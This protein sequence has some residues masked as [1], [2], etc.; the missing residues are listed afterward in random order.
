[1]SSLIH[2]IKYLFVQP[3]YVK[4][5]AIDRNHSLYIIRS[6]SLCKNEVKKLVRKVEILYIEL[7]IQHYGQQIL[8]DISTSIDLRSYCFRLLG[9]NFFPLCVLIG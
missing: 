9:C 8:T 1:M 6:L 2:F 3:V 4:N 5:K 7:V